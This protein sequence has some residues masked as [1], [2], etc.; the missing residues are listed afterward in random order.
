MKIFESEQAAHNYLKQK[1]PDQSEAGKN[2]DLP[3]SAE[4]SKKLFETPTEWSP[5]GI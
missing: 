5:G 4:V 2:Q 1:I 3:E